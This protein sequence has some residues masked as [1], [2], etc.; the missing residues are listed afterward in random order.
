MVFFAFVWSWLFFLRL[1]LSSLLSFYILPSFVSLFLHP[2]TLRAPPAYNTLEKSQPSNIRLPVMAGASGVLQSYVRRGGAPST[3]YRVEYSWAV[4]PGRGC[5]WDFNVS[6]VAPPSVTQ[7]Q[8]SNIR[9]PVMAG[10]SGVL[11]SY[12]RRGGAPSALYRVEHSWA[13]LPGRGCCWD[14]NSQPSNIRLPVM[15]GASGVLQSYV[16]RGGAPS[17]LYRVEHSWAVLPGRGCCWDF[18][19]SL[20]APPS[21][22]QSQPSNIRLPVMAGASGVLQS[23]VRRGGAPSA[24]YRVEHSWVVLPGRGCCWDSFLLYRAP[25]SNLTRP[26]N[27]RWRALEYSA[28]SGGG[29]HRIVIESSH[30]F[31]ELPLGLARYYGVK[32]ES[33]GSDFSVRHCP[34]CLELLKTMQ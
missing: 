3:L 19:V 4:L 11:Q 29:R 10:A 5:C 22:T 20:V 12:V 26:R 14:F 6:L 23:Y 24:L 33:L 8:P 17:A 16:R 9:L 27:N 7:S 34:G 1:S 25:P 28:R 21:V 32:Q 31:A 18:N 15:A 2:S 30:S 13:V